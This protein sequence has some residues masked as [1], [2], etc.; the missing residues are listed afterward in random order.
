MAAS[1]QRTDKR[2]GIALDGSGDLYI[3]GSCRVRKVS[4]DGIIDTVAGNGDCCG[5]AG[6]AGPARILTEARRV[7]V[8]RVISRRQS[9]EDIA[10]RGICGH[11]VRRIAVYIVTVTFASGM[12]EW[13]A[14]V[15]TPRTEAVKDC[16][17]VK[18]GSAISTVR[19]FCHGDIK[20]TSLSIRLFPKPGL[21]R[22]N[23]LQLVPFECRNSRTKL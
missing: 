2:A 23:K 14:S 10:A 22:W 7:H 11:F 8:E 15:T 16:A 17:S 13:L 3:A 18:A 1:Y 12:A 21:S 4:P 5:T 6:D 9:R 19:T 20:G